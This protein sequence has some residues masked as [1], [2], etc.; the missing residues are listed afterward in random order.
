MLMVQLPPPTSMSTAT[1]HH[2]G[3]MS[4]FRFLL[5]F[6]HAEC[7]LAHGITMMSFLPD[8]RTPMS[9]PTGFPHACVC[10]CWIHAR[11]PS[12]GMHACTHWAHTCTPGPHMH[13]LGPCMLACRVPT[14]ACS[15]GPSCTLAPGPYARLLVGPISHACT[16]PCMHA[17]IGPCMHTCTRPPRPLGLHACT[18]QAHVRMLA[19][20]P[21]ARSL[22]GSP[23]MCA[24]SLHLCMLHP[25]LYVVVVICSSTVCI[26]V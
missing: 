24:G 5:I 11:T 15:Q 20:G 3:L 17:C 16:R 4:E 25:M 19:L 14:P 2:R 13:A 23:C 7:F 9:M 21:H 8:P 6:L 26:L 22:V 18:H 10:A 12:Q 1:D